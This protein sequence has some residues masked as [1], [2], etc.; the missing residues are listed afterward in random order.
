[1]QKSQLKVKFA[2]RL[3]LTSVRRVF[4]LVLDTRNVLLHSQVNRARINRIDY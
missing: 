3:N 1:M 2:N 4:L